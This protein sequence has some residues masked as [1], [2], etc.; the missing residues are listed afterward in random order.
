[1]KIRNELMRDERAREAGICVVEEN[2]DIPIVTE[3]APRE[4]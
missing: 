2:P 3:V 4:F 1:M